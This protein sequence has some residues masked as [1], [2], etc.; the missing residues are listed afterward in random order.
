MGEE[1]PKKRSATIHAQ[2][3]TG[4]GPIAG[5]PV[6][7]LPK[8]TR[9]G[10]KSVSAALEERRTVRSIGARRLSRQLLSDLLWSACG[11][12]RQV[13][14]FGVRGIT[15]ASASNSQEIRIYVALKEAVYLYEPAP[16]R[17]VPVAA[18]DLR[19]LVLGE[20]QGNTG[21]TAPVR[22]IYV[23]DLA[24]YDT[25]GYQEPGLHDAETQKAYYYVDTGLIAA[26]VYLFAAS[27][28]LAAWFHNCNRRELTKRLRLG[29]GRRVL[30][31]Q[32]VGY[33]EREA[34]P[35]AASVGTGGIEYGRRDGSS[36]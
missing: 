24:G 2:S 31:A 16:H 35:G 19:A 20:G 34:S 22:L 32:T 14:P 7:K 5:L 13:G 36:V 1:R 21:A 26:N 30:F 18:G 29:T 10:G 17:L 6:V 4:G 15:A 11:V 25:A 9:D 23:V 27:Q 28:G 33:E 8:P 12:N 3:R